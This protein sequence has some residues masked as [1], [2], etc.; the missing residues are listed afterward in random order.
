MLKIKKNKFI[1]ILS[2]LLSSGIAFSDSKKTSLYINN[3][4]NTN[5]SNLQTYNINND[6]WYGDSRPDKNIH[7]RSIASQ[8]QLSA[9]EVLNTLS[10]THCF[11]LKME[12]KNEAPDIKVCMDPS[13]TN[14]RWMRQYSGKNYDIISYGQNNDVYIDVLNHVDLENWMLALPNNLPIL[15]MSIPGTHDSS[16]WSYTGKL[17]PYVQTQRTSSNFVV[18]LNEGIRFF[19]IRVKPEKG[20]TWSLYHGSYDLGITFNRFLLD[21]QK[22]LAKH[23]KETVFVSIKEEKKS[24]GTPSNN[25]ILS[26]YIKTFYNTHWMTEVNAATTTL[27]EV[28]GKLILLNR[29][30]SSPG[31]DLKAWPDNATNGSF[32]GGNYFKIWVQDTYRSIGKAKSDAI[33]SFMSVHSKSSSNE[34]KFNFMSS[35]TLSCSFR[36]QTCNET[37]MPGVHFAINQNSENTYNG[38]GNIKYIPNG[39][40]PM[41]FYDIELSRLIAAVNHLN[42]N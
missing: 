27:Q 2:A 18:Q 15:K 23:P 28:R 25:D 7:S 31:V 8:K 39:I 11:N 12:M 16:T 17:S 37:F 24:V 1:I 34:L 36:P 42:S 38:Y 6:D 13:W 19:D 40:I 29:F 22:W 21:V 26:Y 5:I 30:N 41:D 33:L 14:L 32:S 20:Y 35:S 10:K 4:S 3:F 9:Q